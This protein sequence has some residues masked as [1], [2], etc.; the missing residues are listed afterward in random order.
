MGVIITILI[1]GIG[2]NVVF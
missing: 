2:V 1:I